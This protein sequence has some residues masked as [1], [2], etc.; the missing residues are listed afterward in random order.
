MRNSE[1]EEL[2]ADMKRK[3]IAPTRENDLH[4]A[5]FGDIPDPWTAEH[6]ADLP[7]EL[8]DWSQFK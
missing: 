7:A 2:L 5:Y 4:V 8:Q 6:E 3:G 1:A